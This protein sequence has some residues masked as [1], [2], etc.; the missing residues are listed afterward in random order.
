MPQKKKYGFAD[1]RV[2]LLM[3]AAIGILLLAIFAAS[4]DIRLPGLSRSTTVRTFMGNVDG[5][6]RGGEV[7]LSGVRIGSISEIN[8]SSQIPQSSDAPNLVEIVMDI[9]GT[10]NGRPA[11]E[12]IRT[13]SRAVLKSAGVLGDYVIDI[14]PGTVGGQPIKNGDTIES[15]QQKGVGDVINAAQTA[16]Q[17]FNSISDDIKDLTGRIR[18]G[19]GNVGRLITEDALYVSL[20][21]SVLQA[22][23]LISSLRKGDGTAAKF[24]NDPALYDKANDTVAQLKQTI[25]QINDQLNAGK[26]TFGK[27]LK[28][29]ELYNRANELVKKID[30]ASARLD[31]LIAKVE[32][33]EG[34]LGRLL[35]DEKIYEDTRATLENIRTIAARLERG[36]GTAGKL[37]TDEAL[38]N[39]LNTTSAE[40]TKLLYDFRQNPKKYLSVKVTI[41]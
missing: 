20:N 39:N 4:G 13:D 26:G 9:S 40:I 41:F 18:E 2:G 17:N 31:G 8:F 25:A 35:K 14:S 32:R 15:I 28:D 37:L 16:V 38:Y 24:I 19:K 12:R 7:R 29:E 10:L 22:E 21:R 11:I 23:A 36:E 3:A 34:N 30:T 27:L 5:L 33:G 6:R 1:L